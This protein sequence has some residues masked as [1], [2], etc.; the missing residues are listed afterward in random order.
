MLTW[1]KEEADHHGLSVIEVIWV[2]GAMEVPLAIDRL[3]DR[4]DILSLIHISS[5]RDGLLARMPSSA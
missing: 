2:P 4:E 1:A 5:P 3:L